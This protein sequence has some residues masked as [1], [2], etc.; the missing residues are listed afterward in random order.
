M[1]L[2]QIQTKSDY[3]NITSSRVPL[4]NYLKECFPDLENYS[5]WGKYTRK[6]LPFQQDIYMKRIRFSES[7]VT[8]ALIPMFILGKTRYSNETI[9]PYIKLFTKEQA[10]INYIYGQISTKEIS[11]TDKKFEDISSVYRWFKRLKKRLNELVPLL[12]GEIKTL[13][14]KINLKSTIKNLYTNS[15]H[16]Q[17]QCIYSLT[18]KF[19]KASKQC[20]HQG[21]LFSTLMFLNYLSWK[22]FELPLLNMKKICPD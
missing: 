9:E 8:H 2:L 14:L 5:L 17:I 12:M 20:D 4:K 11:E 18:E 10:S 16:C 1:I 21:E 6:L 3:E 22:K 7:K 13:G 15:D 19:I